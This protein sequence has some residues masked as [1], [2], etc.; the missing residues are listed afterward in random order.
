MKGHGVDSE[1]GS[2]SA[3]LI[4]FIF[5]CFCYRYLVIHESWSRLSTEIFA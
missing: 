3:I 4:I 2:V 1:I 5:T